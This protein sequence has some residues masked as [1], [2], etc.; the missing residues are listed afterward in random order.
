MTNNKKKILK[1]CTQSVAKRLKIWYYH[2]TKGMPSW[3]S[4]QDVALSRRNLGFDSLWGYQ[5]KALVL[6]SAFFLPSQGICNET[7][8]SL[9]HATRGEPVES[10]LTLAHKCIFVRYAI[11]EGSSLPTIPYGGTKKKHLRLRVLFYKINVGE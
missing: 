9:L 10:R 6:A 1:K 7:F 4:G 5:K 3:S 8:V 2:P 11:T